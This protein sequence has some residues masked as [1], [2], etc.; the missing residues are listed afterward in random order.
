[1]RKVLGL[2]GATLLFTG[3][4]LAADLLKA[5]A[6]PL[7]GPVLSW[8]G[9][10][11]GATAGYGWGGDGVNNV[12]LSSFCTTGIAGCP[13]P[14]PAASAALV[15]AI[16][17]HLSPDPKGFIGGGEFGYNFQLGQFVLGVEADFSGA[18]IKGSD[19]QVGSAAVAGFP[20]N[21]VNV[22][23]AA[24]EK[25][26]FLATLRARLGFLLTP[27]LLVYGT[28]GGAFG[29]VSTT[30]TFSEAVGGPCSC[31]PF[32]TV[33]TTT[34]STMPGWTAG[35]GLEWMF[36]PQWSLKGE[37]LYYNLGT[38]S[39]TSQITQTNGA[40]TNFFGAGVASNA[41]IKGSIARAGINFHF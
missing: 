28:G 19:A 13:P 36:A 8:T 10:Y 20:G 40:G 30:T 12:V 22:A 24:S 2:V 11:I 14:A 3:P 32:P 7:G 29:H 27:S 5:P 39:T 17:P 21:T 16:P 1:M 4:A 25:L 34:S 26:D 15:A 23:A 37:Y 18:D 33:A 31:G 35:G 6:M 41:F 38:L 9:W